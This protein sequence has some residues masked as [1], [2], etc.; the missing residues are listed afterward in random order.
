MLAN[1]T[2]EE[3]IRLQL[4]LQGIRVTTDGLF[5]CLPDPDLQDLARYYLLPHGGG[6]GVGLGH[7]LLPLGQQFGASSCEWKIND[8]DRVGGDIAD[9]IRRNEIR[10]WR[11]CLFP[12]SLTP[13]DY[14]EAVRFSAEHR[15]F[16][17][18]VEGQLASTC[19][20]AAEN[21]RAAEAWV[22]TLAAFRRRGYARQVTAAWGQRVQQ[23]G[24]VAFYTFEWRNIGARAL[25]QSLGLVHIFKTL[26]YTTG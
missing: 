12:D 9:G 3:L 18:L 21:A 5:M 17:V 20:S 7:G 11:T 14:P 23:D 15:A 6:S 16:G 24:K 25:A 22:Y 19:E 10:C 8:A 26:E 4:E 1:A 2:A 13:A